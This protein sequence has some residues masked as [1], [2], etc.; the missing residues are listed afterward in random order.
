M[1]RDTHPSHDTLACL[2]VPTFLRNTSSSRASS[3]DAPRTGSSCDLAVI[4]RPFP[5]PS[6]ALRHFSLFASL[7][8]LLVGSRL[9]SSAWRDTFLAS[10]SACLTIPFNPL[11]HMQGSYLLSGFAV[12]YD[13]VLVQK[14]VLRCI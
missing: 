11:P 4:L 10:L 2:S 5:R 1:P 9:A 7:S 8:T 14:C 6:P 12:S 13:T 3:R